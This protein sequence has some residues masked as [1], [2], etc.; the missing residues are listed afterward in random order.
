MGFC[1]SLARLG[2]KS[3]CSCKLV[4]KRVIDLHFYNHLY[5]HTTKRSEQ[6]IQQQKSGNDD[7][8][9]KIKCKETS[10][11]MGWE[12]GVL[13][14]MMRMIMIMIMVVVVVFLFLVSFSFSDIVFVYNF[15]T[16]DDDV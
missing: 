16:A 4:N 1:M 8:G 6:L 11:T 5:T 3:Q 13:H 2:E 7:R 14:E 9:K 10:M 15:M 12:Q